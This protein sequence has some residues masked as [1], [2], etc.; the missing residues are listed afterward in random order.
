MDLFKYSSFL[1]HNMSITGKALITIRNT[2]SG[3]PELGESI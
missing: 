3:F 1:I 2:D